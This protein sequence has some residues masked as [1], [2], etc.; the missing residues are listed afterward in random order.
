M[1]ACP[2]TLECG[3]YMTLANM[4]AFPI[5]SNYILFLPPPREVQVSHAVTIKHCGLILSG[6]TNFLGNKSHP[7]FKRSLKAEGNFQLLA[8]LMEMTWL[9][10][11]P[12]G[13]SRLGANKNSSI[14]QRRVYVD[15]H[16]TGR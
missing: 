13:Q 6:F 7:C 1:R 5:I 8:V 16:D 15:L 14:V 2:H 4:V 9:Y 10:L 11:Q 3:M 12:R